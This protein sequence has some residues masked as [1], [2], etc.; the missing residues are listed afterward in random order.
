MQVF[1]VPLIPL[2][3]I[4]LSAS[5]I[6]LGTDFANKAFNHALDVGNLGFDSSYFKLHLKQNS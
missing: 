5:N 4:S 3:V 1:L 6:M 2:I